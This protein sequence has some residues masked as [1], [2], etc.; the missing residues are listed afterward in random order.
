[1]NIALKII[2]SEDMKSDKRLAS[3]LRDFTEWGGGFAALIPYD[4][5]FT[6]LRRAMKARERIIATVRLFLAERKAGLVKNDLLQNL[7]DAR[8]EDG[9]G[10]DEECI[11]ETFV[12]FIFAGHDTSTATIC[13][14]MYLLDKKCPEDFKMR[15]FDEICAAFPKNEGERFDYVT[16]N[17]LP[18][19]DA[20]VKETLRLYGPIQTM[21]REMIEESELGGYTLRKGQCLVLDYCVAMHKEEYYKKP[22]EFDP[23][24]FMEGREEDKKCPFTYVPFG[25]GAR[26]CLGM[27][28]A[29]M[30]LKCFLMYLVRGYKGKVSS[31][32]NRAFPMYGVFPKLKLNKV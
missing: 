28:L 16:M 3:M 14:C 7:I 8:D 22:M 11:A 2:L 18:L 1:M 10:I 30:E 12:G 17:S 21:F 29:K 27:G 24:R 9:S 4:L 25:G 26:L 20:F 13:S 5:P 23:E 31:F 32:E 19:L 6:A 15:L